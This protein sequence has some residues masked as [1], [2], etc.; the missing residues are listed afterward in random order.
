[1]SL[2]KRQTLLRLA[3][4]YNVPVIEEDYQK[5]FVGFPAEP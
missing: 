4:T 1:M 2:A 5:D 3:N